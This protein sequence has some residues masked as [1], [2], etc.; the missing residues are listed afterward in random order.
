M[1][2]KDALVWQTIARLSACLDEQIP[3]N[4]HRS[5]AHTDAQSERSAVGSSKKCSFTKWLA[6]TKMTYVE[7]SDVNY[8]TNT[9]LALRI[10]IWH[11]KNDSFALLRDLKMCIEDKD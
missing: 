11:S 5:C 9:L 10:F 3:V 4:K 2:I 8:Q 7:L 1:S 6:Q